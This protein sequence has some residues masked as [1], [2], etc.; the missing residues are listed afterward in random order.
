MQQ[1]LPTVYEIHKIVIII[2]INI[3]SG[4]T[5]HYGDTVA[6]ANK[7][8]MVCNMIS[9]FSCLKL[10]SLTISIN[11]FIFFFHK[12]LETGSKKPHTLTSSPMSRV[13]VVAGCKEEEAGPHGDEHSE[14]FRER[15]PA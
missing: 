8:S 14:A 5:K 1:A 12:N 15:E 9:F 11:I 6:D 13:A 10:D 7:P 4:G 2:F 3:I